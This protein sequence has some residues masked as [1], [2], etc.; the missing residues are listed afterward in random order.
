MNHMFSTLLKLEQLV[1]ESAAVAADLNQDSREK[2]NELRERFDEAILRAE[3][4]NREARLKVLQQRYLDLSKALHRSAETGITGDMRTSMISEL[5]SL[6]AEIKK[7]ENID[8]ADL[9][10]E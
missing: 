3:Q 8:S 10:H 1:K 2:I 4:G 9:M 6:L 7:L 5:N